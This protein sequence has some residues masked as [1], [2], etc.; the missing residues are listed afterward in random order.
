MAL[1][2]RGK[3][4]VE[5]VT[6][7]IT[8]I[9]NQTMRTMALSHSFDEVINQ[10]EHGEDCAWKASNEKLELDLDMYMM[11][12]TTGVA[13]SAVAAAVGLLT[14]YTAVTLST[15]EVTAFNGTWQVI[16]GDTINQEAAATGK[17][18]YKLK[19]YVTTAQQT[20][21]TTTPT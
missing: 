18:A 2:F 14:P 13:R 9:L 20:L 1:T 6:N 10:D 19:R 15:C 8:V 7:A 11:S 12:V 4:Q 17:A 21:W 16:N 3:A 5:G